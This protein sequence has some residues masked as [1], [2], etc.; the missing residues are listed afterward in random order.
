[1]SPANRP[2]ANRPPHSPNKLVGAAGERRAAA[3]LLAAGYVILERNFRLG[4]QEINL[5]AQDKDGTLVVA[6]VKYRRGDFAPPESN[7]TPTK[8]RH[9]LALAR[10]LAARYPER[11][12]RIDLLAVTDDA[13]E[14]IP[15]ILD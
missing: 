1:M 3:F 7:L 15:N 9:L 2:R 11:N 6:E 5:L 13:V 8:R 14:H 12:I 4:R 10:Q